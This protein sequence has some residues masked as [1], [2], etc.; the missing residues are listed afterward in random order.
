MGIEWN[1][2]LHLQGEIGLYTFRSCLYRAIGLNLP[3]DNVLLCIAGKPPS[4]ACLRNAVKSVISISSSVE[5]ESSMTPINQP[6]RDGVSMIIILILRKLIL[7]WD[8]FFFIHFPF[9]GNISL[10]YSYNCYLHC[11]F[12]P[13]LSFSIWLDTAWQSYLFENYFCT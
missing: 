6:L 5:K 1:C 3:R 8:N 9:W 12:H 11:N 13:P 10:F 2:S 4:N 7:K